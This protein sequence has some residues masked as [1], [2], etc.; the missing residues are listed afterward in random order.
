ML[1]HSFFRFLLVG[2]INTLIGL[3][4]MFFCLKMFH[5]NYW[6]ST[7]TGNTIGALCSYFFNKSFTFRS[8]AKFMTSGFR[9]VLVIGICY[10]LSY[11]LGLVGAE[12]VFEQITIFPL[13]YV[14]DVAVV[15]GSS[16]YT[17]SNYLGQKHFV[18]KKSLG[19]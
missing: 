19:E 16:L 8:R 1:R 12:W 5:W 11:K 7:F 6:L 9:F 17:I 4:I 15:F 14:H 10:F 13:N 18:F 2:M 3:S